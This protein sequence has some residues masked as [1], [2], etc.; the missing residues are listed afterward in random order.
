MHR[1]HFVRLS[2][3]T[4]ALGRA[5]VNARPLGTDAAQL[6]TR[7]RVREE[8]V[9]ARTE[10]DIVQSGLLVTPSSPARRPIAV[11]WIHG[12]AQ[13]F[14]FPSYVG[15]ARAV[16]AA[17]YPFLTAN[18]RMH[19]LACFLAYRD[20]GDIRGGSYWGLTSKQTLD[21]AAWI[22]CLEARGHSSVVLVGHSAGASAVRAYVGERQDSRVI[23]LVQASGSIE[24]PPLP[25]GPDVEVANEMVAKGQ[26]QNLVPGRI[27]PRGGISADTY[28]DFAK[29]PDDIW[30]FFGVKSSSPGIRKV[31]CPLLAW[32]GS[33]DDIAKAPELDRLR[34]L[35]A[36]QPKGPS[37][38]DTAMIDGAGHLYGG[39]EDKVARTLT[40]WI[41]T[42]PGPSKG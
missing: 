18:T 13:N 19:D 1:R 28:A 27:G 6:N 21:L 5:S 35:I 16:A 4:A 9:T 30:D 11:L 12:T 23:G 3:L 41:G 22:S 17:G 32:Y 20:N 14:Y 42:L 39:Y 33:G 7:S 36:R 38:V 26:G 2:F 40:D 31:H 34:A 37:R 24:L 15:I 29:I 25:T 8:L 10:D